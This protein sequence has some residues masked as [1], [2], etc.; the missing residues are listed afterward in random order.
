M[1]LCGFRRDCRLTSGVGF[2]SGTAGRL[3]KRVLDGDQNA[4][5]GIRGARHRVHR[6]G[7]LGDHLGNKRLRVAEIRLVVV[8]RHDI[9]GRNLPATDG[10]LNRDGALIA[11]ARPGIRAV[12]EVFRI[13][14]VIGGVVAHSRRRLVALPLGRHR[15]RLHLRS[16]GLLGY[17]IG[18]S[19]EH[20]RLILRHHQGNHSAHQHRRH[21][22]TGRCRLLHNVA[23]LR[24][25]RAFGLLLFGVAHVLVFSHI[26]PK[27]H[28]LKTPH[29]EGAQAP[30]PHVS[31][32]RA[33]H[34]APAFVICHV[35]N[36]PAQTISYSKKPFS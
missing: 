19:V 23:H 24:G 33:P 2:G 9:D 27:P 30:P 1:L 7:L 14:P 32:R 11:L 12:L 25:A 29:G 8:L 36:L 17:R 16:A 3:V 5:R 21:E 6:R 10:H 22:E 28:N 18:G 34:T 13:H 35:R 31:R 4:L 15:D 20:E 26:R